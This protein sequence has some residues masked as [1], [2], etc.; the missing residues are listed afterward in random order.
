MKILLVGNPN[1]GKTTLFNLLTGKSA[2]VG[3]WHGVTVGANEGEIRGTKHTAVDLPGIYSLA[4]YTPEEE[5]AA[6]FIREGEVIINV[7]EARRLNSA[8]PLLNELLSLGK[9]VAVVITMEGEL[10][11]LGGRIN[12]VNLTKSTGLPCL[13]A[14]RKTTAADISGIAEKAIKKSVEIAEIPR[15]AF[16][17]PRGFGGR[18]EKFLLDIRFALPLFAAAMAVTFYSAFGRYGAGVILGNLFAKLIAALSAKTAAFMQGAGAGEF[19]TRLFTEGIMSG[20]GAVAVFLPQLAALYACLIILEE[21]GFLSRAAFAFDGF[22]EKFG[23]SGKAVFP[24]IAGFGCTA[25]AIL[26]T[27]SVENRSAQ[28]RAV[29]VLHFVSCSA[30]TPVIMLIASS[31][32]PG[33]EFLAASLVYLVGVVCGLIFSSVLSNFGSDGEL[34]VTEIPPLRIPR[35]LPALKQLKYYLKNIIIKMVTTLFLMSALLWAL[36]SFSARGE[37]LPAERISESILAYLGGKLSFLFAPMGFAGWQIPVAALC[38]LVAK[39]GMVSAL[40][41]AYPFGFSGEFSPASALALVVFTAYYTPCAMALSASAGE[42][43]ARLSAFY[44]VFAFLFALLAGYIT[45]FAA[46][47]PR[48]LRAKIF[49][50]AIFGLGVLFTVAASIKNKVRGRSDDKNNCGRNGQACQNC[51]E[52]GR[53]VF[54]REKAASQKGDKTQRQTG[55]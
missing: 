54:R 17:P 4:P 48:E 10:E 29:L 33:K 49:F 19:L 5:V 32:F 31:F 51:V 18:A 13:I 39:E 45:Y 37:F 36:R 11:R 15:S 35:P 22:L 2:K 50:A 30:R 34:F 23:L 9:K 8:L 6:S 12:P 16:L 47:L 1:S 44:G 28:K 27:R 55:K 46:A 40:T 42:T 3:N 53:A 38:G 52:C 26:A 21:S 24:L 14:D 20:V 7:V 41:I 25:A 43:N